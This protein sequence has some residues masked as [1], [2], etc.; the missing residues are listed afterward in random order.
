MVSQDLFAE[1]IRVLQI[2][3]LPQRPYIG[4]AYVTSPY[5]ANRQPAMHS[6]SPRTV[7]R[8]RS[9][10]RSLSS[11]YDSFSLSGSGVYPCERLP[12]I[13]FQVRVIMLVEQRETLGW[14]ECSE[15]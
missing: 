6:T 8:E 4:L 5:R 7:K 15:I 2:S 14:F 12:R 3:V 1:A 9:L 11:G 10:Y 13:L